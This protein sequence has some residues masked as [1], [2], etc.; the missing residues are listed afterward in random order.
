MGTMATFRT[1]VV[2]IYIYSIYICVCVCVCVC[3]VCVCVFQLGAILGFINH[4]KSL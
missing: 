3:C 4:L 1:I 2:C